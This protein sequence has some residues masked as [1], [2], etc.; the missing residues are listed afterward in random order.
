MTYDMFV[1][2]VKMPCHPCVKLVNEIQGQMSTDTS[3]WHSDSASLCGADGP[4]KKFGTDCPADEFD[5]M[6]FTNGDEALTHTGMSGM[7]AC[8]CDLLPL[9]MMTS[10][11][12]C[13]H[14]A[15][16][17]DGDCT[18]ES[19]ASMGMQQCDCDCDTECDCDNC[20]AEHSSLYTKEVMVEQLK[21][22]HG[23]ISMDTG[24]QVDSCE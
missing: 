23:L 6:G 2:M 7:Y 11:V 17:M 10:G 4:V 19:M 12:T 1:A 20:P 9:M 3:T 14:L 21:W 5:S 22:I 18:G 8:Q 16:F 15:D 24:A 13:Q